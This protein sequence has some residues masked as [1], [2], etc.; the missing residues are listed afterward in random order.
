MQLATTRL[1]TCVT[2][3]GHKALTPG[4]NAQPRNALA[5][6]ACI[7]RLEAPLSLAKKP[8][9]HW[10]RDTRPGARSQLNLDLVHAAVAELCAHHVGAVQAREAAIAAQ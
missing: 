2:D 7:S 8:S 4:A 1:Q 3:T 9:A 6:C 5:V 10:H